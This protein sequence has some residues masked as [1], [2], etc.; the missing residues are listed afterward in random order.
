MRNIPRAGLKAGSEDLI[1]VSIV[2]LYWAQVANMVV[3]SAFM[4]RPSFRGPRNGLVEE[5]FFG[6]HRLD[7]LCALS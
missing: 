4:L 2:A 1:A 3:R 6:H 5:V 7:L